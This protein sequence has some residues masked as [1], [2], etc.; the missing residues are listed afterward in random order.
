MR[1]IS[2]TTLIAA[3]PAAV[4]AVLT[5]TARY[6]EWNSFIERIDGALE[7]GTRLEVRISPP[8]GRGMTFRPRVVAFE[9]ER[10]LA[11]LGRLGIRGI[12]DGRHS[13]ALAPTADG[14]TTFTHSERFTGVLVPLLG[15]VLDRTR[16]GFEA[17]DRAIKQ[18]AELLAHT[19]R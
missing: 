6:G 7:V 17:F 15:R 2:T 4:W 13:F 9:P 10:E 16:Q 11:W 3:P 19:A 14:G 8:N 12:F 1:T 5:D 18:R